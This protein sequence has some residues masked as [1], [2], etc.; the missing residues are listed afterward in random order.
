MREGVAVG[1]GV[2]VKKEQENEK[3]SNNRSKIKEIVVRDVKALKIRG[4]LWNRAAR[5]RNRC[6]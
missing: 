4:K 6:T 1:V 3:R 5:V 2:G